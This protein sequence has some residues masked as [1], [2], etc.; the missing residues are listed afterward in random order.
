MPTKVAHTAKALPAQAAKKVRRTFWLRFASKGSLEEPFLFPSSRGAKDHAE[1][2][3]PATGTGQTGKQA[4]RQTG[5]EA[6]SV[7]QM[8]GLPVDLTLEKFI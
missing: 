4:L 6:V 7:C 3:I 5:T 8:A 2:K 1:N